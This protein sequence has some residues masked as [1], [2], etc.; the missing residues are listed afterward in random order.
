MVKAK[1]QRAKKK[2]RENYNLM[3]G[4]CEQH[5]AEKAQFERTKEQL[6]TAQEQLAA[7][8]VKH[9]AERAKYVSTKAQQ[10]A[11]LNHANKQVKLH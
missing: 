10:A 8:L 3:K 11:K 5:E 1:D 6:K 4:Q 9:E 2:R 7:Q